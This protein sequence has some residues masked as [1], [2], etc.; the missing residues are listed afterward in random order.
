[1]NNTRDLVERALAFVLLMMALS[2]IVF[3]VASMTG[4]GFS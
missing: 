1:M 2:G 3:G 4:G